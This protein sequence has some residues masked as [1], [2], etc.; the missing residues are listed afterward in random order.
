VG[1]P[2][3]LVVRLDAER[4]EHAAEPVGTWKDQDSPGVEEDRIDRG[5][6]DQHGATITLL[7]ESPAVGERLAPNLLGRSTAGGDRRPK[8]KDGQ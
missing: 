4:C 8:E 6:V 2:A 7:S 1:P 5:V 3:G